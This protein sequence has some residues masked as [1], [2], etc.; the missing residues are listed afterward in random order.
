MNFPFRK[1][2]HFFTE[3]EEAEITSAVRE[4]ERRTSGEVRIFVESHCK[5]MDAIDRA[6]EIFFQLKMEKTHDRNA[7]LLYIA[8][9]DRQ[10]ALFGDEGIHAR[11]GT[12]FWNREVAM[13]ISEF[14]RVNLAAGIKACVEDIG[15]SLHHHFPYDKDTDK[16]E[17]PDDIVF[18]K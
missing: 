6:A 16:N 5:Y 12:G 2:K 4:A 7:V 17:L 15:E 13:M 1:K 9:K 18:G 14:D 11:V 10:L 3:A 8:V